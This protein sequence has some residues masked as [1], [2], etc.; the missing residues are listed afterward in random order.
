[1]YVSIRDSHR[2]CTQS[3]LDTVRHHPA[4]GEPSEAR[5]EVRQESIG[6]VQQDDPQ[7]VAL[8]TLVVLEAGV[9]E[10]HECTRGLNSA[11]APSDNDETRE[12]ASQIRIRL[13][14]GLLQAGDDPVAQK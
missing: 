3:N 12:P 10:V 6:A 4:K 13:E 2:S 1:M 5:G 14:F 9:Q 8:D 7:I 11:E